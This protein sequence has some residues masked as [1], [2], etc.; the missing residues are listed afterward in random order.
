[1]LGRGGRPLGQ[2]THLGGDHGEAAAL[3]AG[4]RRFHR[5]VEREDIGLEGDAVDDRDDVGDPARGGLDVGHGGDHLADDLAALGCHRGGTDRQLV[6]LAGMVGVLLHRGGQFLHGGGGFFQVGRLLLGT[7]RQV[8][9]A[10]GDLGGAAINGGGGGLD[11]GHDRGQV[12][13]GRV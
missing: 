9:V 1:L 8:I 13:D 3:F 7:A 4:T 12:V 2:R 5:R 10:G 6:G 11:A